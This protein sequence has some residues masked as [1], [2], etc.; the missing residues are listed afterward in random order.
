MAALPAAADAQ[1]SEPSPNA[2][3]AAQGP[4]DDAT[5]EIIVTG[6]RKSLD[7]ALN[8]KRDAIAA[9]DV[10]V[11][12]DIAKFPDQ[13]LAESLQRIPGVAISR[14]G[15]EGNQI[16]VRG[17]G[18]EYTKV[19]LNGLETVAAATVNRERGFDFN[20]F[21]SELFNSIVVHKTAE[22]NLDEGSLGAVVD[23]N[24][25]NPLS[26]KDGL[27]LVGSAKVQYNDL[28]D[29]VGPRVAALLAWKDPGG[30]WAASISAAYA[31]YKTLEAGNNTVRWQQARFNSVNGT[32]CFTQNRSGGTYV[33]SAACN[34][35]ALAFHPRIPRYGQIEFE[36]ERL[37]LTGSFEIKPFDG[38]DININALYAKYT[39]DRR[40][41]YAEVLFRG[42]ERG[43]DVLNPVIDP[44]TNNL[45]S[46]TF[47]NAW[48]R[49]ED[50]YRQSKN[51]FYQFSGSIDQEFSDT[52]KATLIGGISR[53]EADVPFETT[54]IFDDRDMNGYSYDY[55]QDSRAPKLTF[56]DSITDPS[57]FQFA[58]FRDRPSNVVNDY[59]TVKLNTQWGAAE[60]FTILAGGIF[61]EFNFDSRAGSR[62][63]TYCAAFA[64]APGTYGMTV[65][66][67]MTETY[68]LPNVGKRAGRNDDELRGAEPWLRRRHDRPLRSA[69]QPQ[70]RRYP[71]RAGAHDRRLPP[72]QRQ[73]RSPRPRVCGERG[74]ST[75]G[76]SRSYDDWLPSVNLAVYPT[77]KLIVRGAVAKVMR[78]PGLGTLSP[79]GSVDG[80]NYRVSFGNPQ[81]D[82]TRATT[83]DLSVEWYFARESLISVALFKKDIESFPIGQT[84]IGTYASTGLPLSLI[85]P[86]SPA[87]ADPEGQPW[88]IATTING[89]GASIKG[90][91]VGLQLPFTFLPAPLDGFGFTGNVTYVDSKT[92]YD[93][94]GAAT[95]PLTTSFPTLTP[96]Q[97]TER[98]LGLSKWSAN[99]TLYYEKEKLAVRSSLA[100]RSG[101]LD[102]TGGN[103]NVFDGF[104]GTVFLDASVSYQFTDWLQVRVDGNNLLDTYQNSFTDQEADRNYSYQHTGRVIQ[105]GARVTF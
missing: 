33:P 1:D 6:F 89:P 68:T 64:C 41:K 83:Y 50:Y 22:A 90:V 37:G 62:D 92:R 101:Y 93:L 74:H 15:G 10:I 82:P 51:S 61:R 78:R 95:N 14:E 75:I 32:P 11:A 91:E 28:N 3:A 57:S 94:Q 31:K 99:A 44:T 24:T 38:T 19:T 17:L 20:V 81:L 67:D 27:T 54:I 9:V 70:R 77:S 34:D 23:L 56:A 55:S 13:N 18:G 98:L 25:G 66:P 42:N 12:E 96:V 71:Q 102:T 103:G 104:H 35:V 45:V 40:E 86:S 76:V 69:A 73:G 5:P 100:Y 2:P 87:A 21:A 46:G 49:I 97:V 26:Y 7:A 52:F 80:F 36:R 105:L 16:T 63:S 48:V 79:G 39:E 58:E 29:N 72:V 88:Q 85:I 8:V 47:N 84:I 53:S 30:V 60:G 4:D 59:K 43:I 65:T